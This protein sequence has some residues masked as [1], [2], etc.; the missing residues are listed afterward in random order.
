MHLA[1]FVWLPQSWRL[2]YYR[3]S[4]VQLQQNPAMHP[5]HASVSSVF[6]E[7]MKFSSCIS[8]RLSGPSKIPAL[9]FSKLSPGDDWQMYLKH[10]PSLSTAFTKCLISPILICR[11]GVL[12]WITYYVF[13]S[14]SECN[15]GSQSFLIQWL[16]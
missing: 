8:F 10:S 16:A 9:R 6:I 15:W 1:C 4:S 13:V 11:G 3:G 12:L 7:S 14:C 2:S 5:R